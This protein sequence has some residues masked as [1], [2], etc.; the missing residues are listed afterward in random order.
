M[1]PQGPKRKK[2]LMLLF[3]AAATHSLCAWD[4][5]HEIQIEWALRYLPQE[6]QSFWTDEQKNLMV[7]KWSH[8]P[9]NLAAF[10]EKDKAIMGGD[11]LRIEKAAGGKIYGLHSA[12]G[13][14]AA[15][16]A[17]SQ[18]F[19]EKRSDAA[20]LYAGALLHAY[21]DGGAFNHGSMMHFLTYSRYKHVK[22]PKT[23]L[24]D[25]WKIRDKKEIKARAR[26]I[27]GD[28]K[29][30]EQ[31]KNLEDALCDIMMTGAVSDKFMSSHEA[32]IGKINEDGSPSV[33]A[34]EAMAKTLALQATEGANIVYSAWL[35]AKSGQKL[36][37]PPFD[38]LC[39]KNNIPKNSVWAKYKK[40]FDS[41][42]RACDARN[43]SMYNGLW[44][45][46]KYPAIGFIAE[47]SYE[48]D[49]GEHGFGARFAT[50]Y[51][52]RG[53]KNC[54]KTSNCS[55][56]PTSRNPLRIRTKYRFL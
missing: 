4:R 32:Y 31:T 5:G 55:L 35:I 9:D 46:K 37:P 28:F 56:F 18:T 17:L 19:R 41:Y 21:A 42:I 33:E 7:R 48:M 6:V 51:I 38:I 25:L 20:A 15:L 23:L 11:S 1:P 34:S 45:N 30:S 2:L 36:D 14:A 50:A 12:A 43:D 49:K 29:P 3:A 27:I 16:W 10:S 24:D 22:Y 52:A 39:K 54:G 13:K 44:N 40:T 47:S 8:Y 26:E 53:L